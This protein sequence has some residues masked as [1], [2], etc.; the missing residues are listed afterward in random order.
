MRATLVTAAVL[1]LMA[2]GPCLARADIS[3]DACEV[4]SD[5][6]LSVRETDLRLSRS[7]G[8]PREILFAAG[9][10]RVDGE[11]VP[12]S[13]DDVASVREYE[14]RVRV[15]VSD[16]RVVA[17]DA[18][19]VAIGAV[20]AVAVAFEAAG[21]DRGDASFGETAKELKAQ[22]DVAFAGDPIDDARVDQAVKSALGDLV[23]R[24]VAGVAAEAVRVALSGDEAA[25]RQMEARTAGLEAKVEGEIKARAAG[26]ER[27]TA[28]L[29]AGIAELDAIER[30]WTVSVNE[31][32]LDLFELESIN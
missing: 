3:I 27:R 11:Q 7:E 6:D 25:V 1:A 24:L 21:A 17:H 18:I 16:A 32:R 22:V 5:W 15:L 14:R 2:A 9:S 8:T 12:L 20:S 30:D 23:P 19:D 26:L 28:E 4:Q 13:T 31:Q 29:C 10:L